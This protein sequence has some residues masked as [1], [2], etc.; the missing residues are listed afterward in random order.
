MVLCVLINVAILINLLDLSL[1]FA[2]LFLGNLRAILLIF[3]GASV[4]IRVFLHFGHFI[5]DFLGKL[6]KLV[7]EL[8]L[9]GL[10]EGIFE[11]VEVEILVLRV[12]LGQDRLDRERVLTEV[13]AEDSVDQ[14]D[15]L[16]HYS[17]LL[18]SGLT[19]GEWHDDLDFFGD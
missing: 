13:I 7:F 5:F 12:H 11:D 6:R 1:L 4:L 2:R 3:N 8:I 19:C 15:D 18:L 17:A 9:K 10:V 14:F 16:S